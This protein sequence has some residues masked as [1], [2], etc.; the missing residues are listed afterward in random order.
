MA[1]GRTRFRVVAACSGLAAALVLVAGALFVAGPWTGPRSTPTPNLNLPHPDW[2]VAR[3]WDE[4]LLDAIRRALPNPPVH[5]RNLFHTS[6]AV[7]DT[8]GDVAA[9]RDEAIGY[10]A[11]RVL[12]ERWF[13]EVRRDAAGPKAW[14]APS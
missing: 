1:V 14:Q 3:R 6:V 4:V 8:A 13:I 5:A 11:Y 7:W 10:A 2:S 9:A 12:P